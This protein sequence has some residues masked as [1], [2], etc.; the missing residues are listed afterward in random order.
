MS[1]NNEEF[2]IPDIPVNE[3]GTVDREKLR[4]IAESKKSKEELTNTEKEVKAIWETILEKENISIYSKFFEAGG[5]SIKSLQVVAAMMEKFNVKLE[6]VDLF[7][8]TNIKAFAKYIDSLTNQ[9][10]TEEE[11]DDMVGLTF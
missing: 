9:G 8:Y 1:E 10:T 7:K 2:K 4:Q 3:E 11:N 6:V 5:T